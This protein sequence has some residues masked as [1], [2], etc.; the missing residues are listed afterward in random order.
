MKTEYEIRVLEIDKEKIIKKL[1]EL[2]AIK[3]GKFEQ[4]RYV[5]D[6]RPVEKGKWI[7]LRTNG[8]ITTLTYKNI[9]S[10]TIDGTKEVE[11]EVEDFDKANEFLEKIGFKNRSYQ[12]NE[13]IQYILNNVEIDIDSWPLIPTYMEIEGKSEEEIINIKKFL[14]IDE[15]KVT[16]LNCDDIYKQIYNIDIS[17]IKELKF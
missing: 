7:R 4:K 1:E 10:N 12:E 9:V 3:K 6:L 16:A 17:Q 14:N 2:G 15:T 8:K 13:R 11:F 5:Y